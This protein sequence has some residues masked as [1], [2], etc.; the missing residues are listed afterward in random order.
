MRQRGRLESWKVGKLENWKVG[1]LES[2]EIGKLENWKVGRLE[3][4]KIGRLE[5]TKKSRN[6]S[7]IS[8]TRFISGDLQLLNAK[9]RKVRRKV[10]QRKQNF[11]NK[12]FTATACAAD[13]EFVKYL[14]WNLLIICDNQFLTL[15]GWNSVGKYTVNQEEEQY[16]FRVTFG[17]IL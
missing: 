10:T 14:Y 1:R 2:W 3:S 15:Q 8:F 4:W 5:G 17:R 12:N 6:I 7:F 11:M 13:C 9:Y 16:I